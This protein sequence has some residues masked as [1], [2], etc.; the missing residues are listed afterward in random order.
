M[1]RAARDGLRL[2]G[3]ARRA[4]VAH[5]DAEARVWRRGELL[6]MT[7]AAV[8]PEPHA[9]CMQPGSAQ[10]GASRRCEQLP[11]STT[12]EGAHRAALHARAG[13]RRT[14]SGEG[15][16]RSCSRG[17]AS[18]WPPRRQAYEGS[19][20]WADV[21]KS[22]YHS[23]YF[24]MLSVAT[25]DQAHHADCAG[26]VA[27]CAWCERNTHM[28]HVGLLNLCE[29]SD[30]APHTAL[31]PAPLRLRRAVRA[32]LRRRRSGGR[33]SCLRALRRRGQTRGRRACA[34]SACQRAAAHQTRPASPAG[35][36]PVSSGAVGSAGL[37]PASAP[38]WM[39]LGHAFAIQGCAVKRMSAWSIVA[40]SAK[41]TNAHLLAG[42][43]VGCISCSGRGLRA[44]VLLWRV[45]C[46]MARVSPLARSTNLHA[47]PT[48][49]RRA[50]GPRRAGRAQ[51][52]PGHNPVW[53][54][55]GGG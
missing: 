54:R 24:G 55:P 1:H 6:R 31:H 41:S 49:E 26:R 39:V 21:N 44:C 25:H 33:R 40:G 28:V 15:S 35:A 17:A 19:I 4:E 3:L 29:G 10:P 14:R 12:L 16:G 22:R 38:A 11:C 42:G 32:G 37:V 53:V 36:C 18:L 47:W 9:A 52:R 50:C 43:V 23:G 30:T 2:A 5:P 7:A 48:F 27:G 13:R 45:C 46:S 34:T 20:A 51:V 8:M